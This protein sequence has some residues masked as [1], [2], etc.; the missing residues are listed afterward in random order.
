MRVVVFAADHGITARGVSLGGP[1]ATRERLDALDS[2]ATPLNVLA[3][4]AGAGIRT[5]DVGTSGGDGPDH[6]RSGSGPIDAEDALTAGETEAAVRAGMRAADAEVDEGADVLVAAEIGA[7]VTTP[8]ATLV[9]AVTDTEPVAVVGR[10]SGIDDT[11]W[12]RKATA[13]RD[14]LRRCRPVTG[15]PLGMLQTAGG[16]D[17]AAMAGFLAQ[18]AVRRTPVVLDG[19]PSTA[20]ALLAEELAPGAR[21][22]WLAAHRAAE[23]A[24]VVALEQLDLEPVLDLDIRLGAGTG[25]ATVLPML[26][27]AA[28]LLTDVA[29]RP[30]VPA[31]ADIT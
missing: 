19:L 9:A 29:Q 27:S 12:M 8:A 18:A 30:A 6:V 15:E 22:W 2:G 20:A 5:V 24:Q 14:S 21:S 25:A 17:L 26:A 31:D 1:D 3:D 23:P 13:I 10:G 16:A 28:R 7:G 4:V 11:G